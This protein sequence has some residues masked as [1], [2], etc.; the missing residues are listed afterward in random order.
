MQEDRGGRGRS[1]SLL[2]CR[3]FPLGLVGYV[4]RVVVDSLFRQGLSKEL[5]QDA[6]LPGVVS[7]K[8][9]LVF[10]GELAALWWVEMVW[11]VKAMKF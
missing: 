4:Q 8:C 7:Q 10:P 1:L 2:F 11:S 5:L 3:V 9:L 6:V